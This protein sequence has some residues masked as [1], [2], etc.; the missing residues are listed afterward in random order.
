HTD[1]RFH[2]L[3]RFSVYQGRWFC[4]YR[5]FERDI[6]PMCQAEGLALAPWGALGRGQ[7]KT[8]SE[9]GE[10]G[11]RN[12]GPQEETHRAMGA[13]LTEIGARRDVPVPGPCIAL[14]YLLHKAPYVFPVIG[15]RTVEQL[16]T[17][18]GCLGVKLTRAEMDEIED[19]VPFDVG[20]PLSFLFET[21]HQKYRSDMTTSDIWQVTCNT[22]IESVPMLRPIEPKQGYNRM[23]RK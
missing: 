18:I 23:D 6:L 8:P 11:T 19:T 2:G 4:S 16:E 9:F 17:N 10:P 13:K 1:A 22:R 15:C 21:P 14:A 20:F 12:M 3:T 7:F 5:D